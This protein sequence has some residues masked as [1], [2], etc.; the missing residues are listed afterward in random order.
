MGS[1]GESHV[2]FWWDGALLLTAS[3]L[4]Y[5]FH[6]DKIKKI[7]LLLVYFGSPR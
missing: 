5:S 3:L 1:A 7:G 2:H 6:R 4:P